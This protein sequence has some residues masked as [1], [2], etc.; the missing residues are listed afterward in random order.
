MFW[1]KFRDLRAFKAVSLSNWVYS[2][3]KVFSY[4]RLIFA[5]SIFLPIWSFDCLNFL[6][7]LSNNLFFLLLHRRSNLASFALSLQGSTRI[8][9]LLW[10]PGVKNVSGGFIHRQRRGKNYTLIGPTSLNP[11]PLNRIHIVVGASYPENALL[12]LDQNPEPR[13]MSSYGTPDRRAPIE[14]HYRPKCNL[15]PEPLELT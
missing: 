12:Y 8:Y 9:R 3:E 15:Q 7:K 2:Q 5:V 11:K 14:P 13:T 6:N 10:C 4:T 1:V